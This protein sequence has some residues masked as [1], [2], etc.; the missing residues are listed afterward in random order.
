MNAIPEGWK[1]VR[2]AEC[3]EP[4]NQLVRSDFQGVTYCARCMPR[5]PEQRVRID[6]IRRAA[7]AAR[8]RR[9]L[10]RSHQSHR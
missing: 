7:L 8:A 9:E 1:V 6:R 5:S 4:I 10:A 3:R 2:C